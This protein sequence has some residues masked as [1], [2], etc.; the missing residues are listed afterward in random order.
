MTDK[1]KY[2]HPRYFVLFEVT[3]DLFQDY[4]LTLIQMRSFTHT[5]YFFIDSYSSLSLVTLLKLYADK[6]FLEGPTSRLHAACLTCTL[7]GYLYMSA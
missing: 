7:M 6:L 3:I 5:P 1:N 2:F 4:F